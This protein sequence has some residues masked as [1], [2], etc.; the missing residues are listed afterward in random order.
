MKNRAVYMTGLNKMEIRE[1]E[2]PK[3]KENEVYINGYLRN[4]RL[5]AVSL[6]GKDTRRM[7]M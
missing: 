1:V 2:V 5:L 7:R 6:R 4:P 3:I